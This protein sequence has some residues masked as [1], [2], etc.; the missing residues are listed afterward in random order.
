MKLIKRLLEKDVLNDLETFPVVAI[1][2]PR[3]CGKSTLAKLIGEKYPQFLY[4]DLEKPKDSQKL[5]HSDLFFSAHKENLICLDEIQLMPDLFSILRSEIDEYR[6]NGRFILLGSASRELLQKSSQS[7][8]GRIGYREL[9]PFQACELIPEKNYKQ[10]D[11]WFRGGYPD[12]Y[13]AV[14]DIKSS[15]W[16]ENFI[17]TYL[18]RDIPMLGVGISSFQLKRFI[19]ML[20]GVHGQ[21]VNLSKLGD[22]LSLSHTTIRNYIDLFAQ[23]YLIRI[24]YPFEKKISKRLVKTPKVYFRDSGIFHSLLNLDSFNDLLGNIS[25]GASWEGYALENLLSSLP[26]WRSSF[27]R[28]STGE[29]ID[30]ILEKGERQVAIEFKVSSSP[31]LTKGFWVALD[32][33]G[34]S[35]VY[36]VTPGSESFQIKEN[37][38]VTGIFECLKKIQK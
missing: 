12:S 10:T 5:Q 7:L 16:R 3:Q 25:L 4:L 18:E 36:I 23:C 19:L 34:I 32:D 29:E 14:D 27:Y 6:K 2:G 9:S 13:L 37:V 26:G 15:I 17:A 28:T 38:W 33:L 8:A 11:H 30:L 35:E 24:L 22:S 1:L 31:Q 21:L 20:A